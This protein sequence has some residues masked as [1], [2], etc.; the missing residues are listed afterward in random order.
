[1]RYD[2]M[3]NGLV[4]DEQYHIRE[5]TRLALLNIGDVT[6]VTT[7]TTVSL[8]S[9]IAQVNEQDPQG[10]GRMNNLPAA[11]H[12]QF[13]LRLALTSLVCTTSTQ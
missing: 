5:R 11:K 1:M 2:L 6:E 7:S 9:S 10:A 4:K 13:M 8:Q 12:N 3:K